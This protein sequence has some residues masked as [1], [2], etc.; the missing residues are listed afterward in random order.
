MAQPF[1][2][3]DQFKICHRKFKVNDMAKTK[4]NQ[5]EYEYDQNETLASSNFV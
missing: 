1:I 2:T 5:M 3:Y 4:C